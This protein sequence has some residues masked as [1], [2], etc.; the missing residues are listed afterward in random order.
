MD[1]RRMTTADFAPKLKSDSA[2]KGDG[3]KVNRV[4]R[5]TVHNVPSGSGSH[6]AANAENGHG[7]FPAPA[8]EKRADGSMF[9]I[10]STEV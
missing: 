4:V 2:I 6:G 7:A 8:R 5:F 10:S 1:A 9:P 3:E